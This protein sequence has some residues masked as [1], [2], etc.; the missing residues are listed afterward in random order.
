[1]TMRAKIHDPARTGQTGRAI[2]YFLR[3]DSD[4]MHSTSSRRQLVQGAPCSV[5]LQRTLRARQHWHALEALRLTARV[6][7]FPSSPAAEAFRFAACVSRTSAGGVDSSEVMLAVQSQE[8]LPR[9][10][11]EF[12]AGTPTKPIERRK[13]FD[14]WDGRGIWWSSSVEGHTSHQHAW[15]QGMVEYK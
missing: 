7:P 12:A 3:R 11:G 2:A 15:E 10:K 1:M 8:L 13:K 5:T 9:V 14:L 4:T 6:G